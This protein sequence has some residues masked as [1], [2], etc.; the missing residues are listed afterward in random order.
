M[1]KLLLTDSGFYDANSDMSKIFFAWIGKEPQGI[2]VILASNYEFIA[3]MDETTPPYYPQNIMFRKRQF[4][5]EMGVFPENIYEYFLKNK[6]EQ[7]IMDYDAI[8]VNGGNSFEYSAEIN[9]DGFR[10]EIDKLVN[11]GG[12]YVGIS[13][14]SF[15]VMDYGPELLN[16]VIGC[17]FDVH[18]PNGEGTP[19]GPVDMDKKEAFLSSGRALCII[20]DEWKI[21]D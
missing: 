17:K 12:V 5:I 9:R 20:G 11:N 15:L 4:L 8:I 2:K 7:E 14:G 21:I 6:W 13:A 19:L 1:Y 16:Y 10:N 3:E 18:L